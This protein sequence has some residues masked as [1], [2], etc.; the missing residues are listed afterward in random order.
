MG[1][2]LAYPW[3]CEASQVKGIYGEKVPVKEE[4][5]EVERIYFLSVNWIKLTQKTKRN[6]LLYNM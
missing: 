2:V 1:K 3:A 6:I 5:S 4:K